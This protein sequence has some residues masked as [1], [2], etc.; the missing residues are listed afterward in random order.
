M[1]TLTILPGAAFDAGAIK[2]VIYMIQPVGSISKAQLLSQVNPFRT[3]V[4]SDYAVNGVYTPATD[5]NAADVL[6]IRTTDTGWTKI[7]VP[8]GSAPVQISMR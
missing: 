1:E 2:K 6:G 3:G 7:A 8:A 5:A 4:V